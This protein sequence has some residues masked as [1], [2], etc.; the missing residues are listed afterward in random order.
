MTNNTLKSNCAPCAVSV[1]VPGRDVRSGQE[2][3]QRVQYGRQHTQMAIS[4]HQ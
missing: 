4:R 3:E 1:M 2:V